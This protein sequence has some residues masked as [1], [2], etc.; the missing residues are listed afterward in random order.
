MRILR[1]TDLPLEFFMVEDGDKFTKV[2]I[3]DLAVDNEDLMELIKKLTDPH[4]NIEF[5]TID[6]AYARK[7]L[8]MREYLYFTYLYNN[9]R[10][11][12]K[13]LKDGFNIIFDLA[14]PMK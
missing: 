6:T 14:T 2:S 4:G 12:P 7:N 11:V 9:D 10:S 8:P 5:R 13:D 1:I 3:N